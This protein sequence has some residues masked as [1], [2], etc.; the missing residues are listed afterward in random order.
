MKHLFEKHK[1]SRYYFSLLKIAYFII[2]TGGVTFAALVLLKPANIRA[3]KTFQNRRLTH[4]NPV[5]L[6][7]EKCQK[8]W[9]FMFILDIILSLGNIIKK[10]SDLL[11]ALYF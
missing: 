9:P 4:N 6:A 1:E 8:I 2:F 3:L 11:I 5:D 7:L 10:K